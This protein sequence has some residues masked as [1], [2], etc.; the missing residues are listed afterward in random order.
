MLFPMLG[1][2]VCLNAS[3]VKTLTVFNAGV[4]GNNTSNGLARF[5]TDV[6]ALNPEVC[7]IAFGMNDSVNDGNLVA[8][9]QY[10]LNLKEMIARCRS[11]GTV[12]VLVNINPVNEAMLYTR[13]S[14][15]NY[16]L[17]QGGANQIISNYNAIVKSVAQQTGTDMIDWHARVMS[18]SGDSIAD[19]AIL[20]ID[21]V[22]LS[23]TGLQELA[24]MAADWIEN[25]RFST[26]RI[27]AFGDSITNQGWIE[28]AAA[29]IARKYQPVYESSIPSD[30]RHQ[31]TEPPSK[32]LDTLY[33][34]SSQSV[35]YNGDPVIT[36]TFSK[37]RTVGVIE[38]CGFNSSSY[39]L[40]RV[41][42]EVST[43]G[44]TWKPAG[45]VSGSAI[46]VPA[47]S[48]PVFVRFSVVQNILKFR[49]T[50]VRK[51]G[52]TRVLLSEVFIR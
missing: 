19:G 40:D 6:A 30:I 18:I 36:F 51:T 16:Y 7:F 2:L 13:H 49:V 46:P 12:P 5:D 10:E 21:G 20:R 28:L 45:T 23:P 32:L 11:N 41:V 8:P 35:Q 31:D 26:G 25:S 37:V 3:E 48:E 44:T 14:N 39:S 43:D 42:L 24:D 33:L 1:L 47:A 50:V 52:S 9:A 4:P 17:D 22:H 27:V 29:T 15:T 38:V 34:S